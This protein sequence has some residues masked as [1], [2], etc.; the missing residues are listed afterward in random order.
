MTS[1]LFE[2]V[3]IILAMALLLTVV[4]GIGWASWLALGFLSSVGRPRPRLLA[5]QRRTTPGR[6]PTRP[7]SDLAWRHGRNDLVDRDQEPRRD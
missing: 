5:N 7:R 2:T 4:I 1:A 3:R 6:E